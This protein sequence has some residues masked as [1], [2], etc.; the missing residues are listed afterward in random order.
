MK[1]YLSIDRLK[2]FM[3]KDNF[4]NHEITVLLKVLLWLE[5]TEN[6]DL[7]ELEL[8]GKEHYVWFDICCDEHYCFHDKPDNEC[9]LKNARKD[10]ERAN[11]II[12][13]H[14]LLLSDTIAQSNLIP[15]YTHLIIDEAHNLEDDATKIYT[16]ESQKND[17]DWTCSQFFKTLKA[18]KIDTEKPIILHE[19]I[20]ALF[21]LIEALYR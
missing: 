16:L 10:A 8:H 2:K 18:A 17:F 7:E 13:N 5:K 19:R 21:G 14:A 15:E 6:G 1:N 12:A 9:F 20:D 11:I 3:Q 4:Q